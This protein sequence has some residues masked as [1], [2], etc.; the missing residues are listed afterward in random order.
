MEW[1]PFLSSGLKS[2][3]TLKFEVAK[4]QIRAGQQYILQGLLSESSKSSSSARAT[5]PGSEL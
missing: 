3:P 4:G 5:L 2:S 1:K